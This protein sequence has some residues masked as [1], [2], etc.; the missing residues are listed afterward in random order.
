MAW[1]TSIAVDRW[2]CRFVRR[3]VGRDVTQAEVEKVF[4]ANGEE[5]SL[6]ELQHVAHQFGLETLAV[7][8]D[9][10]LPAFHDA[11][12]IIAVM[13]KQQKLHFVA[14]LRC[15]SRYALLLDVPRRPFWIPVAALR[16]SL[17][18]DGYALATSP[19]TKPRSTTLR[20]HTRSWL[21]RAPIFII[22]AGVGLVFVGL[23]R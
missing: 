3:A 17:H 8:W 10:E 19:V 14:V 15:E 23:S 12:A 9:D 16:T 7:R 22:A 1:E 6:A 18:W 4:P 13:N 5:A 11:P 2:R 20:S 21:G